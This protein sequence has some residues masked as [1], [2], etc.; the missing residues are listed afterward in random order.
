[1]ALNP[2]YCALADL[3]TALG[4]SGSSQDAALTTIIDTSSR[5]IDSY[6]GRR[7]YQD[8]V[9]N[10]RYFHAENS[11]LCE[12]DDISTT[13]GLV[14]AVDPGGT[15]AY[16]TTLTL[17]QDFILEPINA[18][19]EYPAR[20]YEELQ[21]VLGGQTGFPTGPRPGVKVTAKFGWASVP[22]DVARVCLSHATTAYRSP[23]PGVV[24]ES[25][26][27]YD[28]R[29]SDAVTSKDFSAAE[30]RLL[31]RYAKPAIG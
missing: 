24:G 22:V 15:G 14:V 11:R 19:L 20:P 13:T 7:F 8:D 5:E 28:V 16:D 30:Q 27:S 17:N 9:V 18:A 25:V 21:I 10:I 1:M 26:G 29:Y 31:N 2:L 3:K 12:V 23:E 6:C 4:I